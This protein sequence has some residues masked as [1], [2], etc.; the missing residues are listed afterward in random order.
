MLR[1]D[2]LVY[3]QHRWAQVC[4]E[5]TT[6]GGADTQVRPCNAETDYWIWQPSLQKLG[7]MVAADKQL[8]AR[9]W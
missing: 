1:Q 5:H 2:L 4:H 9:L 8:S 6:I 3:T 7:L